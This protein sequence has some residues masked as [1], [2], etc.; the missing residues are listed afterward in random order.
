MGTRKDE[1]MKRVHNEHIW[2]AIDGI[3]YFSGMHSG[4][5]GICIAPAKY[6][7]FLIVIFSILVYSRSEC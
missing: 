5:V 3:G 1:R 7:L 6:M 4:G 2:L